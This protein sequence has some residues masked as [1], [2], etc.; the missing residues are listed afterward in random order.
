[1]K[2][3]TSSVPIGTTRKRNKTKI[4]SDSCT[5]GTQEARF[6]QFDLLKL[7]AEQPDLSACG[8]VDFQRM[9][10]FHNGNCWVVELEAVVEIPD[11]QKES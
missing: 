6:A 1:V 8:G 11:G 4:E 10:M 7:L 5:I 9:I 3:L 2:R